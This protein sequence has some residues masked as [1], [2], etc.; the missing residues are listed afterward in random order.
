[1]II[2]LGSLDSGQV[3]Y[4]GNLELERED[5]T[6]WTESG[7]ES[8][9]PNVIARAHELWPRLLTG[10]RVVDVGSLRRALGTGFVLL[11]VQAKEDPSQ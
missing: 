7:S 8:G 11:P 9:W 3:E 1:M 2:M 5:A 6:R 4:L 10:W